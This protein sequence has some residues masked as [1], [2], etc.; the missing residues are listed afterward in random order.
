M[1][2]GNICSKW[3]EDDVGWSNERSHILIPFICIR[4]KILIRNATEMA[5]SPTV[6]SKL[7]AVVFEC[8][9][10]LFDCFFICFNVWILALIGGICS[11]SKYT[12]VTCDSDNRLCSLVGKIR[13]FLDKLVKNWNQVEIT[14]LFC[15][16]RH[17]HFCCWLS[18]IA[19]DQTIGKSIS[20]HIFIVANIILRH[21]NWFLSRWKKNVSLYH[22]FCSCCRVV[23]FVCKIMN[24]NKNIATII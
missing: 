14:S 7:I 24:A 18:I 2:V 9:S 6:R 16:I 1:P 17:I 19:N 3:I 12:I 10:N 22:M 20:S 13:M 11:I 8:L 21:N 5:M 15:S 4:D 23:L